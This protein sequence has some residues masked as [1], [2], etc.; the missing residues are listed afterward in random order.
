M[1]QMQL[2]TYDFNIKN[3]VSSYVGYIQITDSGYV[4]EKILDNSLESDQIPD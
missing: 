3:T 1:R 4:D 2:W